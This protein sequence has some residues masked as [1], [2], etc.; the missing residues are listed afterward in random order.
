MIYSGQIDASADISNFL[1]EV[2]NEEVKKK[3]KKKKKKVYCY[4]HCLISLTKKK[5]NLC[6]TT[7]K[8][9]LIQVKSNDCKS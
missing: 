2:F 4:I 7:T 1:A 9:L 3:K 6:G 5:F 8:A